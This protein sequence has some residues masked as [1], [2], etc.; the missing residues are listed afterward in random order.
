MKKLIRLVVLLTALLAGCATSFETPHLTPADWGPV[1]AATVYEAAVKEHFHGVLKD[2]D[3]ALYRFGQP[4]RAYQQYGPLSSQAGQLKWVGYL[5]Q[6]EVNAKN[7]FGGYV[8]YKM[9]DVKLNNTGSV[10]EVSTHGPTPYLSFYGS[11]EDAD[12]PSQAPQ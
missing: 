5:V 10:R 8:G 6:V 4:L 11:T 1:P 2:P 12:S 7:S 3:S 9:Y